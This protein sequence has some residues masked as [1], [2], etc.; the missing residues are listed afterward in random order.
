MS[1]NKNQH[2]VSAFY[3][4]NFTNEGQK[5]KSGRK[6]RKTSI[7]HYDKLKGVVKERPIEKIATESYLFSYKNNDGKYDHSL[8]DELREIESLAANSFS[9]LNEIVTSLRKFTRAVCV[10]DEILNNII[11][12]M[13]WQ[14]RRHPSLVEEIQR[15][16]QK[17]SEGKDWEMTPKQMALD[18][19]SG[20]GRDEYSNF[21]E[22]LK[23]KNKTVI[24]TTTDRTGFITSDEPFVRFNKSQPNGIGHDS[25]EIYFPL[26]SNMLLYLQGNGNS[27]HFRV[28]NDRKFL[29]S[30][31]LYMA[32]NSKNYIFG[33]AKEH[34]ESMVKRV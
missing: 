32:R 33:A 8:D 2:Y 1:K 24:F 10:R 9:E 17:V 4:Y 30:F 11:E 14:V 28:E 26:A 15:K 7:W 25:T 22:V 19:I 3:L 27:R 20:F 29:R 31:N 23:N 12:F 18:V 16:C 13:V 21:A 34:I 6:T 5:E